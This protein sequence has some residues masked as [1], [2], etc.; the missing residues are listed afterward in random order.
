MK[1]D[2]SRYSAYVA[3]P[4]RYRLRY[5]LNLAPENDDVPTFMNYGRRRGTCTHE[6]LDMLAQDFDGDSVAFADAER[7]LKAKHPA[8]LYDRC[9]KLAD[10]LPAD[11]GECVVSE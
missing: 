7:A 4:E 11:M 3:N 1:L 9:R 10:V 8:D 2:F 5:Q 6:I